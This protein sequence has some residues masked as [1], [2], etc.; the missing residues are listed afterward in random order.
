MTKVKWNEVEVELKPCPFC[1][2][3]KLKLELT[4]IGG[5]SPRTTSQITCENCGA[6]VRAEYPEDREIKDT[7]LLVGTWNSRYDE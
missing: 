6:I 1:G 7:L 5:V 3:T 2:K 4:T